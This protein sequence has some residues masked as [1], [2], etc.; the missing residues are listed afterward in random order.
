MMLKERTLVIV[1]KGERGAEKWMIRSYPD[2]ASLKL[3]LE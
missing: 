3:S 2:V 1:R